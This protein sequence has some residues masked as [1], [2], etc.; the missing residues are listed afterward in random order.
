MISQIGYVSFRFPQFWLYIHNDTLSALGR[1]A[2]M[3]S[4]MLFNYNLFSHNGSKTHF[5]QILQLQML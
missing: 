4:D 2:D 1:P 5:S 3:F